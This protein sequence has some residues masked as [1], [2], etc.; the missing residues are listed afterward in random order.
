ME[1]YSI[2]FFI[3]LLGSLH[4]V[5][6][7]GPIAFALPLKSATNAYKILGA[8]IY[9]FGRIVTYASLGLVFGFFG[10]GIKVA[11]SQQFLSIGVGVILILSVFLPYQWLSNI[12]PTGIITS[13][14]GKIKQ[15]LGLLFQ[16]S[17]PSNLFLIGLL[18]GFLPCGLV[19]VAIG[20][21]IASGNLINGALFMFFFGLGTLPLMFLAVQL[22]NFISVAFRNK[23]R[24]FFP[25]LIIIIGV[26]FILRGLN[27]NIPYISPKINVERPF[28]QDC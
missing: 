19:Y 11:S 8:L 25:I 21:S 27:L 4:C 1:N 17:K 12:H 20:G 5:G 9:N 28:V 24:K 16:S 23:I 6:M 13:Y 15:Q 22:A 14:I 7:C 26:L 10:Q 18:N 3:G 2:A